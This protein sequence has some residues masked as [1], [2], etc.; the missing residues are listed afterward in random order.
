MD[1]GYDSD[2]V[3]AYVNQLGGTAAIAVKSNRS[4]K[5]SFDEALYKEPPR[6][7]KSLPQTQIFPPHRHRYEKLQS[8]F[9]STLSLAC[10]LI[11]LKLSSLFTKHALTPDK[12]AQVGAVHE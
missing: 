5:L 8:T 4:I 12:R 9:S 3:R 6:H 2:A 7:R 1:K 11:W 10:I